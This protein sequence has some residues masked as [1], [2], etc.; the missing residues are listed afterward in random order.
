MSLL[1]VA[2]L[3]SVDQPIAP[4][5][6]ARRI[7]RL[8][9]LAVL[10]RP[11]AAA[12][13][14]QSHTLTQTVGG[15][16]TVNEF[17]PAQTFTVGRAGTLTRVELQIT[18]DSAATNDVALE[19]WPT[20]AG[21]PTGSPLLSKV[22]PNSVIPTVGVSVNVPFT[23]VNIADSG[24]Q[25]QPG[26]QY[27]IGIRSA[28][29]FDDPNTS[30]IRGYPAYAGGDAYSTAFGRPW[31]SFGSATDFGFKTWVEPPPPVGPPGPR[32]MLAESAR[33]LPPADGIYTTRTVSSSSY[34][35]SNFYVGKPTRLSRVGGNFIGGNGQ[36][37]AALV[38]LGDLNGAPS[39][40][41]FT[42]VDVLKT[43]LLTMP[44][45]GSPPVDVAAPF[46]IMLQPGYYGLWFGSGKFGATGSGSLYAEN[47]Q[48]GARST[49]T[50]AQPSGTRNFISSR[51]R[52]FAEASSIPGTVQLRATALAAAERSGASYVT[53]DGENGI[54]VWNSASQNE[55]HRAVLEFDLRQIPVGAH[56]E[57][58]TLDLD[59]IGR[60]GGGGGGPTI[61]F[62]GYAGDGAIA[63][64]DA[65]IAPNLIGTSPLVDD[66]A[67]IS[68]QLSP[69][70]LQS[71]LGVAT[72]LG[73]VGIGGANGLYG[74][75]AGSDVAGGFFETPLLTI[76]YS[77]P[78][79]HNNDGYV[80]GADLAAWH[81]SFG[82]GAAGDADNDGDSDGADFLAWQR[83]LN[84]GAALA[85]VP[86]PA[87]FAAA[88]LLG[89]VGIGGP[90][91]APRHRRASR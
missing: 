21:A 31:E 12:V 75:F 69:Q 54:R 52:M 74:E 27:A 65:A 76:A 39:P 34:N 35:G 66:L 32:Y 70:Y 13:L 71:L 86:E 57:S 51:L 16:I 64:S 80:D 8:F 46:D 73:L 81:T 88:F 59:F 42:G 25:V 4:I 45:V 78:A 91:R 2:V 90:R 72:H 5:R 44:T 61:S 38:Q 11:A 58:V 85:P 40:T 3:R 6:R 47:R 50:L 26:Q 36:I 68:S 55:D 30:W 19:I 79:D 28:A 15:L 9:L 89:L 56:I 77:L 1:S 17:M 10:A 87:A 7:A 18:R 83:Q 33:P 62:H 41:D 53:S 37:F 84:G 48:L 82:G 24:L 29:T 22:I 14:D 67:V 60:Q 49:W 43:A 63:P 23:A 20:A